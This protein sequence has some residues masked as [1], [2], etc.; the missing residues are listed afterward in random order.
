MQHTFNT[1]QTT[2]TITNIQYRK[3]KD[4]HTDSTAQIHTTHQHN[5]QLTSHTALNI[6]TPPNTFP[7]H[8]TQKSI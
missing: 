8:N 4:P 1:L 2:H 3:H 7:I 5:T 6:H